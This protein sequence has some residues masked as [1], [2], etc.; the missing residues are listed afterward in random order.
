MSASPTELE[1]EGPRAGPGGQRDGEHERTHA[2]LPGARTLASP[3]VAV[4]GTAGGAGASTLA[5]LLALDASRRPDA[6]AV[7]ALDVGGPLASLALL[8]GEESPRS[9]SSAADAVASDALDG[10]LFTT[11]APSLRLIARRPADEPE[12]NLDATV[13]ILA[14]ARE[15]HELTVCDCG[16]LQRPAERLIA[17]QAT[18]V[19]WVAAGSAAGLERSTGALERSPVSGGSGDLL[20]CCAHRPKQKVPKR[21]FL[22]LAERHG[23]PLVL[24][25]PLGDAY[26]DVSEALR[27][28][29]AALIALRG[30][31]SR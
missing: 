7:L 2:A 26:S 6:K 30:A 9:L 25:P 8:A 14:H 13:R 21:A 18:H 12:P 3:L 29:E 24:V 20:A 31:L 16:T 11:A 23:A 1:L 15:A 28:A 17:A 22:R 4:C 5:Y 27:R 19:V 10:R